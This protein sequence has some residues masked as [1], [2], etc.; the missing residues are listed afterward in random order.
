M[1]M[2]GALTQEDPIGVAGGLNLYGY[3]G[4]D[5]I[6]FSDPFGLDCVDKDGNRRPCRVEVSPEGRTMGANL[7]DLT[8]KTR[9]RLHAAADAAGVDLGINSTKNGTHADPG[10]AAGTA[11]DIGY[12]NG[13]DIGHG[14]RTNP[15]MEALSLQVQRA[16][17][18]LGGLKH[19]G[20]LGPAG[21]FNGTI[22][23]LRI[24]DPV[25]RASHKNHIHL[26]WIDP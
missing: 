1:S 18:S 15:G 17:A 11:V 19:T 14:S 7:D 16:A 9:A 23:P 6:N 21:K 26:S 2:C 8:P 22:G 25:I 13:S 12:L 24:N 5:P 20:N 10:H 3:A 4:G